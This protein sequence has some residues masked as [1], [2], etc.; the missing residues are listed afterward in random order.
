MNGF[1]SPEELKEFGF[2]HVGENVLISKKASLYDTAQMSFGHDIRIDDFCI[3]V[4]KIT[5]GNY[6]HIAPFAGLHG[7]GGG[8]VVL[9]DFCSVASQSSIYSGSDD[10]SGNAMVNPMVPE[11]FRNTITSKIVLGKYSVVGLN[12]VLLPG[13]F[14]AEG[15]SLGAMSLLTKATDPWGVHV[16]I[17]AKRIK[18]RS[19]KIIALEKDFL[20]EIE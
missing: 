4:G 11:K 6:I 20:A 8:E 3:L 1:Y 19:Q 17:P 9:E 14:L 13:A 12:C 15:S 7:S 16:G 10:F 18:D 5:M 2:K